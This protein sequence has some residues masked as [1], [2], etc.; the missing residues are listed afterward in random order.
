MYLGRRRAKKQK[1]KNDG[2]ECLQHY[3][4]NGSLSF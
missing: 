2:Y 3:Y 1:S 4:L